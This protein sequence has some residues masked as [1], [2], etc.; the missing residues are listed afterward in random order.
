MDPA[1]AQKRVALVIGNA[2]Y[3]ATPALTNPKNDAADFA[4]ALKAERFEVIEG[5][6]LTKAMMDRR[7][8]EFAGRL[9]SADVGVFFYAGH[10]LQVGGQN[11]LVPIDAQL[12]TAAALDFEMV[13]LDLVQRTMERETKTNILFLDACRDNPLARNLARAMGTRSAEIGRGLAAAES[14]VGTLI[15]YSTQPGNVALDG[16]GRNSPFAAALV[17]RIKSGSKR[18]L[19]AILIDVRN[20]VMQATRNKQVPWEHSA[21]R[22][23]FF[24]TPPAPAKA[25]QKIAT[26]DAGSGPSPAIAAQLY[27]SLMRRILAQKMKGGIS[28]ADEGKDNYYRAATTKPLKAMAACI[29]WERSTPHRLEQRGYSFASGEKTQVDADERALSQ[30]YRVTNGCQCTIIDRS[31]VNALAFPAAWVAKH[32]QALQ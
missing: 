19:S 3:Q 24:F 12:T 6:D 14:G 22:A 23:R 31:D 32:K 16:A 5:L 30:C 1:E 4:A 18:D 11:Y 13:R 26:R 20:D 21:L 9:T 15:S 8:G 28:P 17:N 27:T 7:I 10:G 29:D 25:T 2:A